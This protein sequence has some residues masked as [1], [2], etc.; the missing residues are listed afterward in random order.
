MRRREFIKA[1][2]CSAIAWPL[3][4]PGQQPTS[5]T[6]GFLRN[7]PPDA[8]LTAAF[9][10]GLNEVGYQEGR[11]V[12][13]AYQW[14]GGHRDRLLQIA[15]SLVSSKVAV[16]IAGGDE[17]IRAAS[18]STSTIPTVFVTGDDP[19]KAGYVAN[20]NHPGGNITG[21][22]FFSGAVLQTKQLE[23]LHELAPTAHT[24]ALLTNPSEPTTFDE[25]AVLAAANS[26][27]IK[28]HVVGAASE[29]EFASAFASLPNMGVDLLMVAGNALFTSHR[30]QLA[31][32]AARY[33]LPAV[34]NQREYVRE[35]GLMS[36]GSSISDAYRQAGLYAGRILKGD[37]PADLPILQATKFELAIN[38]KA[39]KALEL[40]VPPSFLARADEVIE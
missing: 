9:I 26:F 23:L 19:V 6:I 7:S 21:T 2:A 12:S 37:K 11:N 28:L 5:P 39:A 40:L 25:G 17:A 1:I 15:S 31:A 10:R 20:L 16:I 33:R 38:L 24:V 3:A 22:T 8:E 29:K 18:L 14:A 35:G 27:E 4:A 30:S 13:L 34:Y 36:Y 32:L